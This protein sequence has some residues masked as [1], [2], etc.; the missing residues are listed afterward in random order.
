MSKVGKYFNILDLFAPAVY[1]TVDG[2]K[3]VKT[4]TGAVI[5]L[6]AIIVVTIYA[7]II[8]LRDLTRPY[9]YNITSY[10]SL[11]PDDFTIKPFQSNFMPIFLDL[12][13]FVV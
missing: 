3:S 7:S 11:V 8:L 5:G 9:T 10:D 6:S 1:L 2:K 12:N 4:T 13:Y